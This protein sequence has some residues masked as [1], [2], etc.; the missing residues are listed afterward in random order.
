MRGKVWNREVGFAES[1]HRPVEQ[2]DGEVMQCVRPPN[3]SR[4]YLSYAL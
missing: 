4:P 1:Y 3:S 2:N